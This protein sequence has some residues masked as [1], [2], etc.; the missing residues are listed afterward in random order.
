MV[1]KGG[2]VVSGSG[3]GAGDASAAGILKHAKTLTSNITVEDNYNAL[4][5]S[6]VSFDCTVSVNDGADLHIISF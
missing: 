4:L 1:A 3:G 6:P 2:H 5:I